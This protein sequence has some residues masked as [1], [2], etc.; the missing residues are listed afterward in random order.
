[1]ASPTSLGSSRACTAA[2]T[3]CAR[4]VRSRRI[5]PTST[6]RAEPRGIGSPRARPSSDR[7]RTA[8]V[9]LDRSE[10]SRGARRPPVSPSH[11]WLGA[12]PTR[13]CTSSFPPASLD[14]ARWLSCTE[15][16]ALEAVPQSWK[17]SARPNR[18]LQ[19]SGAPGERDPRPISRPCSSANGWP[20]V[21][22]NSR[23][24][25]SAPTAAHRLRGRRLPRRRTGRSPHRRFTCA[26]A[27]TGRSPGPVRC[28]AD[29]PQT[30]PAEG[31]HDDA[32]VPSPARVAPVIETFTPGDQPNHRSGPDPPT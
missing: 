11:T 2:L 21:A 17:G 28:L 29:P 22:G 23:T 13:T 25:R 14:G 9:P 6:T 4:E 32:P 5:V 8:I 31:D 30:E 12:H 15:N 3:S 1:M 7:C 20:P 26:S 16:A 19:R 27:T 18:V 10:Q 24:H